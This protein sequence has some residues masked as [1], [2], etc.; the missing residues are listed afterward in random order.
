MATTDD[1]ALTKTR[2]GQITI[3]LQIRQRPILT[4]SDPFRA[5]FDEFRCRLSLAITEIEIYS[6][7]VE[8]EREESVTGF[9]T[10]E[11]SRWSSPVEAHKGVWSDFGLRRRSYS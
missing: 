6:I 7:A 3:A 4:I 9:L 11:I 2:N 1:D 5:I 8:R 10:G